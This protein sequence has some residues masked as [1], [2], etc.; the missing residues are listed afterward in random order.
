MS[1]EPAGSPR[2]LDFRQRQALT[3]SGSLRSPERPGLAARFL[4]RACG[5]LASLTASPFARGSFAPPLLGCRSGHAVQCLRRPGRS[6]DRPLPFPPASCLS[7]GAAPLPSPGL[8]GLAHARHALPA[9]ERLGRPAGSE[10]RKRA[11]AITGEPATGGSVVSRPGARAGRCGDTAARWNHHVRTLGRSSN[12][13]GL[14][15]AGRSTKAADASTAGSG[16]TEERGS[17]RRSRLVIPKISDFRR[18]RGPRVERPG[19]FYLVPP[20]RSLSSCERPGAFYLVPPSRS[21]SSC[22]RPGAF[23]LVPSSTSTPH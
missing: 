21:L 22:E 17:R 7:R 15:G 8:R 13:A 12:G 19:A 16:A 14:K 6:S 23:Y 9:G 2:S 20:S 18:Q 11:G 3:A 4:F 5:S 10:F 1:H